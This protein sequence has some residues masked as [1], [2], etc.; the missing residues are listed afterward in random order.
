MSPVC[1]GSSPSTRTS[2]R[3]P[4]AEVTMICGSSP[5]EYKSSYRSCGLNVSTGLRRQ[6][7]AAVV[8][9]YPRTTADERPRNPFGAT[10]ATFV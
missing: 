3:S 10:R 5:R 6:N 7:P 8:V 2:V 4:T 1:S 9:G